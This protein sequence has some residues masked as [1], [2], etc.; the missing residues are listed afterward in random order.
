MLVGSVELGGT[1]FIC[2]VSDDNYQIIDKRHFITDSPNLTLAKIIDYFHQYNIKALGVATFGPLELRKDKIGFGNITTSPHLTWQNI[3]LYKILKQKLNIPIAL[4]TDVNG[5]AYGE[6][7]VSLMR[8]EKIK[9]LIYY[10]IDTGVGA[11]IIYNNEF[12][13]DFGHPE[14]G[15]INV[16]R[17]PKDLQFSGI[18]HYHRDC[19]EGLVSEPTFEARL[20]KNL[21]KVSNADPVWDIMAYYV[22]QALIQCTLTIRPAKIIIGG[23]ISKGVFL[24][25]IKIQFKKLLNGYVEIPALDNYLTLPLI[26]HNGSATIGNIALALNKLQTVDKKEL[27]F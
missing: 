1:R 7:I 13:G 2:A 17:H 26:K 27:I 8:G 21:N 12:L 19:L 9:S 15:H 20:G 14:M 5:A 11:G 22:A 6:Y 10:T 25:K 24:D 4:T 3:S 16:K 18:C 23:K